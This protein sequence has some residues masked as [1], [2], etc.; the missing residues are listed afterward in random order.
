MQLLDNICHDPALLKA[1]GAE[2]AECN[3][4]I[5]KRANVF[6]EEAAQIDLKTLPYD[7]GFFIRVPC[8]KA[9]D[10]SKLLVEENGFVASLSKGVRVAACSVP[11]WQMNGLAKR[12]QKAIAAVQG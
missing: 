4:L 5:A 1:V 8:G 6:V 10:L 12:I 9:D 7:S 3:A 11:A 2:R